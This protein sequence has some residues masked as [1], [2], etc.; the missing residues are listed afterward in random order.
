MRS[1]RGATLPENIRP[2]EKSPRGFSLGSSFDLQSR[3]DGA[4]HREA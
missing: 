1:L 2:F 4:T 3:Q